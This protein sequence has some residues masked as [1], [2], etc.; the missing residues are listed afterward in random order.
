MGV[1]ASVVGVVEYVDAGK[2][3]AL[4]VLQAGA[5]PGGDVP[6]GGLV[7]AELAHRSGGVATADHRQPVDLGQRLRHRAGTAGEGVELEDAHGPVPEHGS[8]VGEGGGEVLGVP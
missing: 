2:V 7:E 8:G 5:S 4:E 6:E 1:P 3:L